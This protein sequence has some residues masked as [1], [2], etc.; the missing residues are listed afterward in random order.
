[1]AFDRTGIGAQKL[2]NQFNKVASEL[3]SFSNKPKK[4]FKKV[5]VDTLARIVFDTPKDTGAAQAAWNIDDG[6]KIR[7]VKETRN[8]IKIL[9]YNFVPYI[10]R[11]EFGWS[12]QAPSGMVRIN[13]RRFIADLRSQIDKLRVK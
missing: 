13:L 1:M 11:L 6:K 12:Q 5:S 8:E 10:K 9:L 4:V 7:I 3:S 2:V